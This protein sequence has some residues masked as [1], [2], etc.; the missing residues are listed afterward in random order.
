MFLH[1]HLNLIGDGN[2]GDK[3]VEDIARELIAASQ[4]NLFRFEAPR[5]VFAFFD[6]VT[7]TVAGK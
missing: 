3:T 5:I 1:V 2:Y 4:Q 7:R 6:G